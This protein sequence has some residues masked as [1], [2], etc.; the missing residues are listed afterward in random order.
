MTS[1][2]HINLVWIKFRMVHFSTGSSN[3]SSVH[4]LLSQRACAL[5]PAHCMGRWRWH[6]ARPLT[7]SETVLDGHRDKT[8]IGEWQDPSCSGSGNAAYQE[9]QALEC[10]NSAAAK[11]GAKV[12]QSLT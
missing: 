1:F 7:S 12:T 3:I 9:Q 6:C 2:W 5:Q 4:I 8:G 10:S 11:N